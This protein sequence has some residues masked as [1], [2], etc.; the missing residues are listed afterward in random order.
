MPADSVSCA[1]S[2]QPER[3]A[4]ITLDINRSQS[5]Q[6]AQSLLRGSQLAS[7]LEQLN[8]P[9]YDSPYQ[10]QDNHHPGERDFTSPDDGNWFKQ[11]IEV[12]SP[13]EDAATFAFLTSPE[14]C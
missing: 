13:D 9:G 8:Q 6:L 7:A 12:G 14:H 4:Q 1:V 3:A 11:T 2:R 10:V 5:F